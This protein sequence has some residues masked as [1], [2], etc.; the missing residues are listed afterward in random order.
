MTSFPLKVAVIGAGPSGFYVAEQVFK[1]SDSVQVHMFERLPCP[2]GLLR[3]G[4]A[5]DHQKIKSLQK[6][7]DKVAS[8]DHFKF[9]GNIHVGK[10][11]SFEE[12]SASYHVIILAI[13]ASKSKAL[14]V[15]GEE[16]DGVY[17]ASDLVSGIMVI[18]ITITLISRFPITYLV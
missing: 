1:Q 5:P 16:L 12:L 2:Y 10:N 18:L 14:S 6:S 8:H 13:G 9:F 17:A 4:V 7:F 15:S 11:I 3:Y